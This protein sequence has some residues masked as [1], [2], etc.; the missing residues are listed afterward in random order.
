MESFIEKS[1]PNR[2][3]D[4]TLRSMAQNIDST[5]TKTGH[6]SG[7]VQKARTR[8][9]PGPGAAAYALLLAYLTGH[10]GQLLF[11]TDF[12]KILDTSIEHAIELAELASR[13]GYMVFNRIGEVIDVSFPGL[14]TQQEKEGLLE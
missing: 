10:R 3:S 2:Y 13:R 1:N 9:V 7:K 12:L 14:L 5:W 8:A 6:L 4:A 11:E